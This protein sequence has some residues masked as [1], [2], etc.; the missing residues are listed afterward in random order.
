MKKILCLWIR[1]LLLVACAGCS[2]MIDTRSFM[3]PEADFSFYQRVGMLPFS[4][5][6]ED[7]LAGEKIT[8]H[9]MTELLINGELEVMD[10][11]QF[12]AVAMQALRGGLGV[13]AAELTP[14][15]LT[16]IAEMAGVQGIFM[17]I[18]HEYKMIQLGGEQYPMISMT[19]KFIDAPT[20]TVVWQS[21]LNARG[22]PNLPIV[23][24]GETFML[25]ELTQKVCKKV[26]KD[27]YDK[28][29]SQ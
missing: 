14:A 10:P 8:E 5:Q 16:Q 1:L 23:S 9:F 20:G 29:F 19:T 3:H 22:G 15:Q 11:G 26:V 2:S 28:A 17:G 13:S 18:V 12:N 25:G 24:I 21:N 27:F 7:R 4:N 6:S